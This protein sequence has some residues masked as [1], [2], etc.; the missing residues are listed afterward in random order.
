[1]VR[2]GSTADFLGG[3]RVFP[4]GAVDDT[5]RSD[6]ANRA[7]RW[8][9]DPE[10]LPWRAAALRELAEETGVMIT[11]RPVPVPRRR[12]PAVFDAVLD[13]GAILM[14]DRLE[15]LSNWVTPVG[16]PRRYDTRFF[17]TIVPPDTRPIPDRVEVFDAV[18]VVPGEA[19]R[20]GDLG[21]WYVE[22]PTRRHLEMLGR[23]SSADEVIE[24]ARTAE[25]VR[26]EPR[27]VIEADDS[28]RVLLPG[29][30]GFE[31]AAS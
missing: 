23:F 6:A 20:R 15:Y 29:D 9:G 26:I 17:V 31:E 4:G 16:L 25:P 13:A 10:E 5:D 19:I 7:V 14:A 27:L 3:A 28:W 8:D 22:F 12:G 24:F 1:M 2:R 21:E 30:R 18:W 11:D